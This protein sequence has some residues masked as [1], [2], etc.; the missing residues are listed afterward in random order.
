MCLLPYL[1]PL[2][3]TCLR[4]V[5]ATVCDVALRLR[6]RGRELDTVSAHGPRRATSHVEPVAMWG[7]GTA[8]DEAIASR[9]FTIL[10]WGNFAFWR[11]LLAKVI[12]DPIPFSKYYTPCPQ[13][14]LNS[15]AFF[16]WYLLEM[17]LKG[18]SWL[19]PKIWEGG[20]AQKCHEHPWMPSAICTWMSF[21]EFGKWPGRKKIASQFVHF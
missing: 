17:C 15:I 18:G 8:W 4:I 9:H 13:S 10:P 16:C 11:L 6:A 12:Y 21:S 2:V 3:T 7:W 20:G 14:C 19:S 5:A 1:S